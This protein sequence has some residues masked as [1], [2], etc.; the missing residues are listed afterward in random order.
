MDVSEGRTAFVS[1][2]SKE[3]EST[4]LPDDHKKIVEIAVFW[5]VT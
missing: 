1:I 2:H 3:K 4:I 5:Y